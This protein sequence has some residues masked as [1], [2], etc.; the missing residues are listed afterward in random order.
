M[1]KFCIACGFGPVKVQQPPP[2]KPTKP[3]G[4][5]EEP[6]KCPNCGK[7]GSMREEADRDEEEEE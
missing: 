4:A 1:S 7:E 3:L 6:E 2:P 5:S